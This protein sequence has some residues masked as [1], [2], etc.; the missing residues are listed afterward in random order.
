LGHLHL[1]N[2]QMKCCHQFASVFD[3][4][5]IVDKH[6]VDFH[7]YLQQFQQLELN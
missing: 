3:Q 4:F 7:P 5:H 6:L 2:K 1:S